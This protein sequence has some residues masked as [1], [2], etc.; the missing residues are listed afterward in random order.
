MDNISTIIT[1]DGSSSLYSPSFNEIYHSRN[2]A[3]EEAKYV[4]IDKALKD[5]IQ[6]NN[7]PKQIALF[8][9]GYGTGL[10]AWLAAIFA[11]E[12]NII[13]N[14]TGIEKY[15]LNHSLLSKLNY[16]DFF[17]E[18]KAY[19]TAIQKAAWN[20]NT[21]IHPNFICHKLNADIF[22][23]AP[24]IE[25]FSVIFFDAFAPTHQPE[26][27]SASIFDKIYKMMRKNGIL[28]TY[29]AK[30]TV[31]NTMIAA[32]F[33]IEKLPGPPGKREMLRA[34]KN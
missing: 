19:L 7:S 24:E 34:T 22:E 31:R 14:Y 25:Q 8:E 21:I 9:I 1:K 23:Y 10:N 26:I 3:I 12:K 2:G 16:A 29:C 20:Q 17:P 13:I 32:G 27:W 28:T 5:Y 11:L 30:S 6:K 15:P 33:I 18:Y 4:Y